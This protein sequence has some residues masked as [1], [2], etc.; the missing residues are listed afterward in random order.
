LEARFYHAQDRQRCKST[1]RRV[2]H[3]PVGVIL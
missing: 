2:M 1:V 3:H